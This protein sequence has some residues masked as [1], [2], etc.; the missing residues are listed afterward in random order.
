MF[1]IENLSKFYKKDGNQISA[2]KN[3]SIK[4]KKGDFIAIQGHSGSGKTTML[5]TAGGLLRPDTGTV[6]INNQDIYA[7]SS[8]ARAK[9]R[10]DNIG[11]VFQQYHLIP[12]LNVKE[13][14]AAPALARKMNG[15]NDRVA[16]L[17]ER[18][19]LSHRINHLPSELSAGEKQ[20]TALARALL[21]NPSLL[22]A[23]EVTG[24]LDRKNGEMV[25]SA[26][27]EFAQSGGIVILV[28][29]DENSAN[30]ADSILHLKDG[31][32]A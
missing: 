7:L 15:L 18:F 2:L 19:G 8:N 3:A 5:L 27:R 26:L 4:L 21:F 6:L 17:I 20:R 24:N 16:E 23:D 9:F 28:T 31:S 29:H 12:Y 1:K 10:A 22:L 32:I 14:I 30:S 11:F 25:L 13:N